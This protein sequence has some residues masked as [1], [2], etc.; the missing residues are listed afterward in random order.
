[1]QLMV[2]PPVPQQRTL[3]GGKGDASGKKLT[4]YDALH[5]SSSMAAFK[6]V[7]D[8]ARADGPAR[9]EDVASPAHMDKR[10]RF[11]PLFC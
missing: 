9:E 6:F 2:N 8:N 11:L 4:K 7:G 10:P 3:A 5:T 1:M